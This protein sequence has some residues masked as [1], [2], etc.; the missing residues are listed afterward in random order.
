MFNL[1]MKKRKKESGIYKITNIKNKKF[2]I[3]STN[4]LKR[5]EKD[6]FR[7]LKSGES[8]CKILQNA[9]NKHGIENF[10]YEI[11]AYCPIDFLFKLEQ[12]FVD[13]FDPE[14]N[15]CKLDVSVPIGL[16]H[17]PY[18]DKEQY[19]VLALKR[20][21]ENINFG[22]KS[23]IILKIDGNGNIIKE[24][25]S[26]KEYAKEHNCSIANVGKALKKGNRCKG[27]FVKYKE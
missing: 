17:K 13:N 23:R 25:S 18:N 19:K 3:G 27:F 24:Y 7:L 15:I 26:L 1:I 21:K 9:F 6:H 12:W 10:T 16:E 8:H 4:D 5:R 20:L 11:V 2:Y 22:W 14:Y